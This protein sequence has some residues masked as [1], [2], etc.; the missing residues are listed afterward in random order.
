MRLATTFLLA[1]LAAASGQSG[2]SYTNFIRQLQEDSGVKWDMQVEQK[3]FASSA[4][5]IEKG[6]ALFQLWTVDGGAAKDFLLDQKVVGAYLP[7]AT[8]TVSSLDPNGKVPR[9]RVDQ[10]FTVEIDVTGLLT[11]P[12]IPTA[13][14]SV[15]LERHLAPYSNGTSTVDPAAAISGTPLSSAYINSNGR[16]VLRFAASSLTA[17]D[18]TKASGEEHFVIH[19]LADNSLTQTQ[20]AAGMVQVW[21]V[22]S[23]EIKGIRNGEHFSFQTPKLELQ[24]NNLYPRSDTYLMLFEGTQINGNPG[25]IVK[26]YPLDRDTTESKVIS[27]TELDSHFKKD[28]TYTLALMS[29]T[30]YGRELLCETVT[31]RI[32]RTLQVNVMQVTFSDG[33]EP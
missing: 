5:S 26:A 4:L 7:A 16:T 11:G 23:G 27:V 25:T 21:P 33:E 17:A 32:S 3:G 2:V 9:T 1:S 14:S 10:P 18:P 12:G 20:I 24:L 15:L 19:T 31:F 29:D 13:A 22:A 28:G 8:L 30:V 6:G